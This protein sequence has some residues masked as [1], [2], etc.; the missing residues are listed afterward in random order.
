MNGP[1]SEEHITPEDIKWLERMAP[2]AEEPIVEE[3]EGIIETESSKNSLEALITS[4]HQRV[5]N[6]EGDR[7]IDHWREALR[8][9]EMGRLHPNSSDLPGSRYINS[10]TFDT[11]RKFLELKDKGEL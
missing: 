5:A 4:Y 9:F 3:A 1:E 7:Y 10:K 2:K 8:L 11:I 6:G